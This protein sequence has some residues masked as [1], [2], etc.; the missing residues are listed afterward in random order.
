MWSVWINIFPYI[1]SN[2]FKI[3]VSSTFM[4]LADNDD[5]PSVAKVQRCSVQST[6]RV[7]PRQCIFHLAGTSKTCG[8][9]GLKFTIGR[10]TGS[11]QTEK[12]TQCLTRDA[13]RRLK[14]AA[15]KKNDD[16][17]LLQIRGKD[18]IAIEVCY[19]KSCYRHYFQAPVTIS[20]DDIDSR[21]TPHCKEAFNELAR[22]V[23]TNVIMKG[24]VVKMSKLRERFM[25]L[26]AAKGS[27]LAQFRSEKLKK[28]LISRFG[29]KIAF[30]HPKKRNRC[31]LVYSNYIP[32]GSLLETSVESSSS[33]G[34]TSAESEV[35]VEDSPPIVNKARE[36]YHAAQLL[37]QTIQS[38]SGI[39]WPPTS[40]KLNEE[41]VGALIPSELHNFLAWVISPTPIDPNIEQ[42]SK[43]DLPQAVSVRVSAIAQDILFTYH[44]GRILTPKH[45]ALGVS[46]RHL[47]KN[48][49]LLSI[50]NKFG[51]SV[52]HT[53]LQELDTTVAQ[54]VVERD[55]DLPQNIIPRQY[56]TAVWDN[57]DLSEET[58]SGKGTTH[59]TNGILVQRHSYE[60]DVP[61]IEPE[62]RTGR[63][64]FQAQPQSRFNYF[65]GKRLGPG[66]FPLDTSL[67]RE[68]KSLGKDCQKMDF[69]WMLLRMSS[70]ELQ[71][72][73]YSRVQTIP[74]WSG[75]NA[76]Q[77]C[78]V[79]PQSSVGYLPCIQSSP[80]ELSTVY[81]LLMKTMEICTKLEQEEIVVVL[82][83]AIYSK[84]LQIVWK[85]SQRFNKVILRLGAFHT[86]CVMLGVIGKR[87]DDAG[88]R[89]VLIESGVIAPGSINGVMTGKHYNR[90]TRIFRIVYEALHRLRFL[91]FAKS[92]NQEDSDLLKI[93]SQMLSDK[94]AD[95]P[96]AAEVL[97]DNSF[98]L[99]HQKYEEFCTSH[100]TPMFSFWSS[101]LEMMQVV[102]NFIR[103]TRTGDFRLHLA[104]IRS[105]LPWMF[106]YDRTNYM[107]YCTVY[108]L[109]MMSLPETHPLIYHK[110]CEGEFVVQ[111][112]KANTFGQVACDMAIE[113]TFNRDTKSAGGIVGFS[114]NPGAVERWTLSSPERAATVAVCRDLAGMHDTTTWQH[115]DQSRLQQDEQDVIKV[116]ETFNGFLNPFS[117]ECEDLVH[118]T[119]G[120][121]P[122]GDVS[123]DI[124]GAK[125]KGQEAF[126]TFVK[127]RLLT[128]QVDFFAPMKMLKTKTFKGAKKV[129][130]VSSNLALQEDRSL[131]GNILVVNN[132]LNRQVRL[133]E[134]F[135]YSLGTYPYALATSTGGLVK[136]MK[137]KLLHLLERDNESSDLDKI[138]GKLAWIFDGMA[139]LQQLASSNASTFGEFASQVFDILISV[140][141][142]RNCKRIDFVTDRYLPH[143]IKS[144]ERGKRS[145]AGDI[146]VKIISSTQKKTIQW[147]KFLANATNKTELVE[148]L[149]KEWEKAYYTPKLQGVNL[150]V[151]H[152][153]MCHRLSSDGNVTIVQEVQDLFTTQEEADTRMF[154]HASNASKDHDAIII[155]SPDTD[156]AVLG[157]TL[158][159]AIPAKLYLDIGSKNQ[160]RLLNLGEIA[161]SLG[162]MRAGALLGFHAFTGCDAVSS[163]YGKGKSKGFALFQTDDDSA[164]AMS[165]LGSTQNVSDSLMDACEKFVCKLYGSNVIT[166]V[167][168]L[169]FELFTRTRAKSRMLPPNKDS[170]TFHV[171]RANYQAF[172][173]KRA[174]EAKPKIDDPPGHGWKITGE[175]LEIEWMR[176][177]PAPD[178]ILELMSCNC[179]RDCSNNSCQCR[180][181]NLHCTD[182]C[183]CD[184][185]VNQMEESDFSDDGGQESDEEEEAL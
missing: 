69:M 38:V 116:M 14:A 43:V 137:S 120:H 33:Q 48:A 75:F 94:A 22:E 44:R 80:T 10:K 93:T 121:V 55:I 52:S 84:A 99:V 8:K 90:A 60:P 12:L 79:P 179:K 24:E 155:R 151:A 11:R 71:E 70:S 74:S 100:S 36:L 150:F 95:T 126:L 115:K 173:W 86:T 161:S 174:L 17:L 163:F 169:R 62:V 104:S 102:L 170:L 111:R 82:D 158:N 21:G 45:V 167:N 152:G 66:I 49:Q 143:S 182:A 23:E 124:L 176:L 171:K 56:T 76:L 142:T 6:N 2:N 65:H 57:I 139:I 118:L 128:E 7:L 184:K 101:F 110:L 108:W 122:E 135:Q 149:V 175:M 148:F 106:A 123:V 4:C 185:C 61:L 172:I 39:S 154:L 125:A 131:F 127:E 87:F 3:T 141:R 58:L 157:I 114:L 140:T 180:K 67:L 159:H 47:T 20:T 30:W 178:A 105:M 181:N 145:S 29:R 64:S 133:E 16:R 9:T 91:S 166:S 88:L 164:C 130:K 146:R 165:Q 73:D 37:R 50:M 35:D 147:K 41:S 136:T 96:N 144:A 97:K 72:T 1:F 168:T 26:V 13:E 78:V 59:F 177:P 113:Q 40:S 109:Q 153:E 89:D 25:D 119:A 51:H 19:H 92:L 183:G 42:N 46:A 53:F 107:R 54:K 85:E 18:L 138:P 160:R 81:S 129:V 5:G 132:K 83:Q 34:D 162:E 32:K 98:N 31:E 156:V 77:R 117:H 27:T 63:R 112:S 68:D 103:A 28:K 15:E 134:L